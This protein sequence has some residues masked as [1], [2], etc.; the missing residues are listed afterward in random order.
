MKTEK[1]LLSSQLVL[2]EDQL[3][4]LFSEEIELSLL[5]VV[6]LETD[7]GGVV[8]VSG[9]KVCRTRKSREVR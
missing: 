6:V 2:L 7:G 5:L 9:G 8:E 4:S 3:L 1:F